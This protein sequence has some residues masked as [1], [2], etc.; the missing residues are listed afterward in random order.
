MKSVC[1]DFLYFDGRRIGLRPIEHDVD[2][3]IALRWMETN[4]SPPASNMDGVLRSLDFV[5]ADGIQ[6][7][8]KRFTKIFDGVHGISIVGV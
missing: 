6:K 7:S 4:E 1:G 8:E 2:S 3:Q 5:C